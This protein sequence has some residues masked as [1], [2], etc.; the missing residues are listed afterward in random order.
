MSIAQNLE[1]I[2]QLIRQAETKYGRKPESVKLIAVSKTF[3]VEDA[4][5][6]YQC[7]QR[8]FGENK[9][10]EALTKIPILPAD[11]QWHLIGPLQRNKVRKI[12]GK[13]AM[14]HTVDSTKLAEYMNDVA[15]E[16][17]IVQNVLLEVHV[18]GE[19]SKFGFDANELEASWPSLCLLQH[20]NIRG[21]MCIPPPVESPDE[22]RH[23]FRQLRD[24]KDRLNSTGLQQ[25][26]ELSM[27]MSHDFEA[28]IAEGATFV[29]VG[30][31]I[32][33]AR[34]YSH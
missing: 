26:D 32:F 29:R 11:A 28:A 15:A 21:L 17:G 5:E 16:L 27:G 6:C 22:A 7:G 24:L 14:I 8:L 34:D 33:G 19:E 20:L 10:Q 4:Q 30:T 2:E 18:G 31:A 13:A 9:V 12:I 23:Y 1:H 3:P 25:L